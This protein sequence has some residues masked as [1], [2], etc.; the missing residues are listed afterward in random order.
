MDEETFKGNVIKVK[1]GCW[2]VEKPSVNTPVYSAAHPVDINRMEQRDK[3]INEKCA[4]VKQVGDDPMKIL[5]A[6]EQN[7]IT[8]NTYLKYLKCQKNIQR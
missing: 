5:D 6:C 3:E 8:L 7:G 1:L 2:R 4:Q